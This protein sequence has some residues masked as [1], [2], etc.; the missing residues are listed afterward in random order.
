M[1]VVLDTNVVISGLISLEEAPAQVIDFWVNGS[2]KIATSSALIEEILDVI[3][4]PKFRP[5]GTIDERCDLVKKLFE[6]AEIVIPSIKLRIIS[7][8]ETDNRVLECA[9]AAE[10]DY[11]ISGDSHLLNLKIY[12]GIEILPPANFLNIFP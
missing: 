3:V 8:D 4:R 11:I 10:A 1:K 12:K 2:L 7:G 6:K 5:L 9:L